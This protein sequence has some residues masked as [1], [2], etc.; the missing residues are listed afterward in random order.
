MAAP[1]RVRDAEAMVGVLSDR[2]RVPKPLGRYEIL[3]GMGQGGMGTVY[4]RNVELDRQVALKVIEGISG[5]GESQLVRFQRRPG[6]VCRANQLAQAPSS[7]SPEKGRSSP[8]TI[9]L[10]VRKSNHRKRDSRRGQGR[11][12]TTNRS[13]SVGLGS[14][15]G[16]YSSER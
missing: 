6:D 16:S 11:A 3:R 13:T 9:N 12:A 5:A 8:L 14:V 7:F 10:L 4:Q 2:E 1:L 15:D